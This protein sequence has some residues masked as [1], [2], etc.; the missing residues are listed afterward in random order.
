MKRIVSVIL[1]VMM[2]VLLVIGCGKESGQADG[3]T[4]EA[5]KE[6]LVVAVQSYYCSSPVGLILAENMAEKY[7][8]PFEIEVFSSGATINEAMGEWDI[9]VTGGAFIY[10][11][12]NYDCKLIGH[13]LDGTG[14][15]DI[16]ARDGDPILDVLGDKEK[17]AECV[18]GSTI[19][20]NVGTTGHYALTLWLKNMGLESG[21]VNLV[22]QEF[23]NVYSSWIAGEGD[24]CVLC[25]PYCN[26]DWD[27]LGSKVVG[28]LE[29]EGGHLYEATVCTADAYENRYDDVVKFVEMLYEACDKLAADEDLAFDTVK[30]WYADYGKEISDEDV[31]AELDAKPFFTSDDAK[32][33]V[34]TDFAKSYGEY[35]IEQGLIEADRIDTIEKNCASDVLED[36]LSALGK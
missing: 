1:V 7:D 35:F 6:P 16:M 22:S 9:A 3:S 34:L 4:K 30:N 19:L 2:S 25:A 32:N 36:A 26:Y 29:S 23:A 31:Q 20:T 8:C 11:L 18:K 13:Q 12:A 10:A 28:T 17:M 27:E 33:I 5:E 21:D 24:F 14:N 15:N